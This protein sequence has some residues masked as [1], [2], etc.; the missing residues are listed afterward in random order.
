M[1]MDLTIKIMMLK[2]KEIGFS[3]KVKI[4]LQT[5]EEKEMEVG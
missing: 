5:T 2:L 1:F 3:I 4:F